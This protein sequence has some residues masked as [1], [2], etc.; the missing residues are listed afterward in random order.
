MGR[1]GFADMPSA[2]E[3]LPSALLILKEAGPLPA[4]A[5]VE[6]FLSSFCRPDEAPAIERFEESPGGNSGRRS[7]LQWLGLA[8]YVF[9]VCD[10]TSIISMSAR[11]ELGYDTFGFTVFFV[12]TSRMCSKTLGIIY[13]GLLCPFPAGR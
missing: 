11:K 13:T 1:P 12:C 5:A 9:F 4:P 2:I 6:V 7:K 3:G 10:A 8:S